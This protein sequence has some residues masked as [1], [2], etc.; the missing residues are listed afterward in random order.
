MHTAD[1]PQLDHAQALIDRAKA[2]QV[3]AMPVST[4]LYVAQVLATAG[5]ALRDGA[6]ISTQFRLGMDCGRADDMIK[7]LLDGHNR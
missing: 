6:D 1:S 4:L 2:A 3:V 7:R 5:A